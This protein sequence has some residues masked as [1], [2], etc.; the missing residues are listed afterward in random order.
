MKELILKQDDNLLTDEEKAIFAFTRDYF[1]NEFI[2]LD[3]RTLS[4]IKASCTQI[5][6]IFYSDLDVRRTFSPSEEELNFKGFRDVIEK[7]QIVVLKMSLAEYEGL[8]KT[9]AAY[10]KLDFMAEALMRLSRDGANTTRPLI[11]ASD[12]YQAFVTESDANYFDKAREAKC[13]SLLAT[14]SYTSLIS[15]LGDEKT[16][17]S[18]IQNIINKVALRQVDN[19]TIKELMDMFGKED[20]EK[21]SRSISENS[22]DAKK[23]WI[24]GRL[25]SHKASVSESININ[26][27]KD[28]IF[29]SKM[30]TQDLPDHVGVCYLS[31][32]DKIIPPTVVHFV[33]YYSE[34]FKNAFEKFM[35]KGEV[36]VKPQTKTHK[37]AKGGDK[38]SKVAKEDDKVIKNTKDDVFSLE[39]E[40]SIG[41]DTKVSKRKLY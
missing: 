41:D 9:I 21:V 12:E 30:F 11:F 10:M 26:I 20:K 7:G 3:E 8:A 32:G 23:S 4:N 28:H 1:D 40:R 27:S 13:C 17:R 34:L 5:L 33:P 16:M 25:V 24:M 31:I 19:Y 38:N 29:E 39:S 6:Q 2:K 15:T 37:P 35:V 18:I 14:Q 22:G 36:K